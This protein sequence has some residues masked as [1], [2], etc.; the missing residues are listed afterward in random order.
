[1]DNIKII[2]LITGEDI[3][4][5]VSS[6]TIIG[7]YDLFYP[8]AVDLDY[9]HSKIQLLMN[10]WLP[11]QIIKEPLVTIKDNIVICIIEPSED[12]CEYYE[13][14]IHRLEEL[15]ETNQMIDNISDDDIEQIMEELEL[16]KNTGSILH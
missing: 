13:S 14:T 4:A 9:S 8:M 2:R 10:H 6:N 1:M 11:M 15:L 12:L 16:F 5:Q 7:H 3:V